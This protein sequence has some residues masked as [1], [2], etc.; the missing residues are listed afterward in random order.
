MY[1][2]SGSVQTYIFQTGHPVNHTEK[3]IDG[4]VGCNHDQVEGNP[5]HFHQF[6]KEAEV[7]KKGKAFPPDIQGTIGVDQA[8]R[9]MIGPGA[10]TSIVIFLEFFKYMDHPG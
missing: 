1:N 2:G 3:N 9:L 6:M 5:S 4:K 8:Q 7:V 10:K